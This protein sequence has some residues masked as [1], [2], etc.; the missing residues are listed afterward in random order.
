MVVEENE[1][2]DGEWI[3]VLVDFFG[4]EIKYGEWLYALVAVLGVLT[5]VI[6]GKITLKKSKNIE[7]LMLFT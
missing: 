5:W 3:N 7:V 4:V 1:M 6:G 2:K